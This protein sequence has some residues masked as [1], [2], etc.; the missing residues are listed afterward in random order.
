MK[1]LILMLRNYNAILNAE[2]YITMI[3]YVHP[4]SS[5]AQ[6]NTFQCI[7]ATDSVNSYAIFK[8]ADGLI[9]WTSGDLQS[10]R[11]NEEAQVGFNEGDGENYASVPG[12]LT[13]AIIN[14]A[15]KSNVGVP[16]QWVAKISSSRITISGRLI[17]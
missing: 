11:G 17:L 2:M 6:T 13:T 16:G 4:T 9:Q 5:F 3:D 15:S 7:L 8:Y 12:S 10:P 1:P 14:I